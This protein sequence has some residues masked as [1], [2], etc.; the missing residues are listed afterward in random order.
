MT[1]IITFNYAT[2]VPVFFYTRFTFLW[3]SLRFD[4]IMK[5]TLTAITTT[6][7]TTEYIV[8]NYN[9]LITIFLCSYSTCI[10]ATAFL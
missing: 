7:D 4:N 2:Y 10:W 6:E 9:F 5:H 3:V 8:F 1:K